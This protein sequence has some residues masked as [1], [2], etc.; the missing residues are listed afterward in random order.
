[1]AKQETEYEP[2]EMVARVNRRL[3]PALA[4]I[5]QC[6]ADYLRLIIGE[7]SVD[8]IKKPYCGFIDGVEEGTYLAI[9]DKKFQ[10]GRRLASLFRSSTR[11]KFCDFRPGGSFRFA[12]R[13]ILHK[14]LAKRE[15]EW[16]I[17]A[18]KEFKSQIQVM[19]IVVTYYPS[20]KEQKEYLMGP[21]KAIQ[22]LLKEG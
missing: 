9:F 3:R 20:M 17:L 19:L 13:V 7:T 22:K 21:Q 6:K 14:R 8:Y 4:S 12:G 10:E 11:G 2:P 16:A 1:M 5:T 18:L 15:L